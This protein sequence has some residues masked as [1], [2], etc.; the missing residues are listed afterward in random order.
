MT[1][2]DPR[3][4]Q[5]RGYAAGCREACCRRAHALDVK[6]SRLRKVEGKPRSV[7]AVGAQRR[8]Q[9]LMAM[10][11][12]STDIGALMAGKRQRP[13]DR[14]LQVLNG[15]S[16]RPCTWVTRATHERVDA[17]FEALSGRQPEMTWA[18]QRTKLHALRRGYRP[19]LAW[20]DIDND[21]EPPTT[22]VV[23]LDEVV[24]ERILAGDRIEA[25]PAERVEVVRR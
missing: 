20:D 17:I 16:G 3:H 15:Q 19:P 7:P 14:A 9:A 2:D 18:R 6:L 1:P 13:R 5:P 10:G 25:T 21:P 23:D 11:W 12:T 8:I 22:E 4:G 24:V